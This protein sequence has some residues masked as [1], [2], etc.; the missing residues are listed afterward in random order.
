MVSTLTPPAA[1]TAD[2]PRKVSM[3]YLPGLDGLRAIS[4]IAVLL[5]H[6]SDVGIDW[7]PEGGFL[8]V[9]IFFVIS[10]YLITALLLAEFR[11]HAAATG[12]PGRIDLRQFWVRRARRL[13]PALYL[14]LVTVSLVWFLFIRDEMYKL[15]G[16]VVAALTY[17]TN[18]YLIFSQQSYFEQAGRPSPL[19]HLWSLAV[20]EQFYLLWPL[21]LLI[22]L[23]AFRGRNGHV[24]GVIVAGALASTVLMAVLYEPGTDP[25]RVYYGTDTRAAGLLIG[26]A[27]AFLAAPW[28]LTRNTGRGAGWV[29]DGIGVAMLAALG[30]F[31]VNTNEFDDFLYQ[32]GFALLSIVTAVLIFVAAHPVSHLGRHVLG[33]SLLVWVGVRSYG[34]YLWHW[35][36]YMVTRPDLDLPFSGYPLL[37]LRFAITLVLAELSFRLLERPIRNGAIKKWSANLRAA[38]GERRN[39]IVRKTALTGG[40]AVAMTLVVVGGFAAARPSANPEGFQVPGLDAASTSS[41]PVPTAPPTTTAATTVPTTVAPTTAAV[42][43]PAATTVAPPTT[44]VPAPTTVPPPPPP[45]YAGVVAI[46]DSVMLG[47]KAALEARMPGM[48]VDAAVNRQVKGG[49]ELAAALKAQGAIGRAVVVHLGTNGVTSQ[50]QFDE[51][52]ATL[53]D[54]P[55]VVML[56]TKVPRPWESRV[57]G[58]IGDT[59]GRYPN[60]V[61]VDWKSQGDGHQEWFWNDGIHLRPEGAA[62]FAELIAQAIG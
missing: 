3:S 52:M 56:N 20:E 16:D 36:V 48:Y 41:V 34:I 23:V 11:N 62:A 44:P 17:V 32:G 37:I 49:A 55:R 4:V 10:G 35:P 46:G 47:A 50:K 39:R 31:F 21:L 1:A 15:R 9:E 61:F 51:L 6:A 27:L 22:L 45:P 19:R 8:G 18:W 5:Y 53:G 13:L 59:A 28:R 54:V 29:I 43:D 14:L 2:R 25:S 42:V 40:I 38:K 57:N 58:L 7:L 24:F 12:G 26:A 60:V 30:W 33:V